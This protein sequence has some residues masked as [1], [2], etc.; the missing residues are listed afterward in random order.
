MEREDSE[1]SGVLTGKL[2][3]QGMK[4][5]LWCVKCRVWSAKRGL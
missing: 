5:K 1:D 4:W 3:V 2:N